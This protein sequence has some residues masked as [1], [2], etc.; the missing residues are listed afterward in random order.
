MPYCPSFL[1]VLNARCLTALVCGL[2]A[3]LSAYGCWN[4][5]AIKYQVNPYLL[6][7]I[8]KQESG[9]NANAVRQ[10]SN[11]TKDIGV[12]QINSSWLPM[13]AKYGIT[14]EMLHDPCINIE[15]GAWIL[16]QRQE[17]FGNTWEAVGAYHSMTPSRKWKYADSVS[18]KLQGILSGPGATKK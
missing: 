18:D 2:A 8:A 17:R 10:N 9:F 6:G 15:V 1:P 5:V 13:L 3:S 7:A 11:G 16:R 4:E 14:E 12:M